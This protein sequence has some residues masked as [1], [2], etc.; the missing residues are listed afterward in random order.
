MKKVKIIYEV[1]ETISG[2]TFKNIS[3]YEYD[4]PVKIAKRLYKDNKKQ[5]QEIINIIKVEYI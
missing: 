1:I 4:H 2:D 3:I 5:Y